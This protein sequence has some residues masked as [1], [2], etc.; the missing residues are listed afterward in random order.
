MQEILWKKDIL[1]EDYQKAFRL[2]SF[3]LSNPVSLNGKIIKNKRGLE[4]VISSSS[5]YE[6]SLEK[7]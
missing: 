7:Y 4:L 2:T 3:F 6:T 5:D 1:K